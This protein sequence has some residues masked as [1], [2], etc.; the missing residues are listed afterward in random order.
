MKR[1]RKAAAIAA[2]FLTASALPV[3]AAENIMTFRI[4]ANRTAVSTAELQ[5]GDAVVHSAFFIDNYTAI[6]SMKFRLKADGPLTIENG[7]FTR[8]PNR[9]EMEGGVLKNKPAFFVD[10]G[11]ADYFQHQEATGRDNVVSWKA[12]NAEFG[13]VGEIENADSSF[14]NFDIRIPQDTPAGDYTV[15]VSEEVRQN[16]VGQR[17]KD[18]DV[19]R[20][21]PN[22]Q[23]QTLNAG[24]DFLL[25]PVTVAVY[26]RGDFNCD[27][28]IGADDAQCVLV[29][30]LESEIAHHTLT[31]A[32]FE[33]LAG[34][35]HRNAATAAADV[36][37]DGKVQA[38]DSQ[39]IL[40]YYLESMIGNH[41][42]WE[43]LYD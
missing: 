34:T 43:D 27:G 10:H 7:D 23:F 32:E 5:R 35:P 9:T 15:Y 1:F 25:E 37:Q 2:A 31:D 40:L 33:E 26:T 30:F 4:A 22:L 20:V 12:P 39:I 24:E 21:L 14:V 38:S 19:T 28:S 41:P 16:S 29:Y 8:D 6:S 18:L 11:E 36:S 17:E 42:V 3:S 13:N